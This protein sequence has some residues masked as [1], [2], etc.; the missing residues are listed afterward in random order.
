MSTRQLE[1]SA[2]LNAAMRQTETRSQ[3]LQVLLDQSL[4]AFSADAVG[5]YDLKESNLIYT[6]G[7][8]LSSLPPER[9][10]AGSNSVLCQA[11]FSDRVLRF[12][13]GQASADDCDFC[14][15]LAQEGMQCLLVTPL[16]TGQRVVGV[17]FIALRTLIHLS[18]NDVQ[19]LNVFSEAAGNTLHRFQILEQLEQTVANREE[20]LQLLYDLMVIAG[21]TSEMDQLLQKSLERILSAVDCP[22]GVMHFIDPATQ[23][24][25]IAAR[26]QYSEDFD[27]YLTISGK[28]DLLWERVYRD[29]QI[30][31]VH[32]LPDRSFPE[33]PNPQRQ[34]YAY[35]GFPI[36]IKAKVVGVLSLLS[37][38]SRLLEPAA[39]QLVN[40]AAG[41][42]GLAVEST[43]FRKQ[44]EDAM[45]LRERQRLG[46]NL[47]DSVSQSLYALVIS[48]DVSE[49]LLRI[50]DF[51]GL[52]KELKD[53]GQVALQGLKEMRL[54]LYEFRPASLENIGLVK[55]LEQRLNTVEGRAGIDAALVIEGSVNLTPEMEQEIYR[56]TIE[57]L[58]NSLKHSAASRVSVTLRKTA[59]LFELEIQDNGLGF[60]PSTGQIAGGM[61]LDSMRERARIL[62]GEL[63]IASRPEEG[64]IIRLSAPLTRINPIEE[65]HAAPIDTRI[66][67]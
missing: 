55:A 8:G 38:S 3:A 30:V 16:R 18:L 6:A 22:I 12:E 50:K 65:E 29:Q 62:G 49:K 28:S 1:A 21:E 32:D 14:A 58:N 31:T 5:V 10:P 2:K 7:R 66:G 45:I 63:S 51:P 36:R 39:V 4:Q 54:L 56:I 33:F 61:G 52:R 42:L 60:D 53:I 23:R 47:H 25:K 46:R 9:V 41:E 17:L 34:Y 13:T 24:V 48:A 67:G 20:E 37:P 44:A 35:L 15:F 26:E 64:T 43:H 40:S 57:G 59:E 19:L 27:T 11:M